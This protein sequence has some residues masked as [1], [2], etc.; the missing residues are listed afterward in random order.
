MIDFTD[1]PVID[2]HCHPYEHK[3]AFLEPVF[4]ARTFFHGIADIPK[5]EPGLKPRYWDATDELQHHFTTMGVV[6]TMVCQLAKVFDCPADL[7]AVLK[8]G[9][10]EQVKALRTISNCS[11]TMLESSELCWTPVSPSMIRFWN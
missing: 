6:Q 4:L 5:P 10:D 11:M 9:I 1:V 3:E 8:N 2:H 7:K